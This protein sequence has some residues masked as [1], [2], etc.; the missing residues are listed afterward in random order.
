MQPE[1]CNQRSAQ[2]KISQKH[3]PAVPNA[4]V[5]FPRRERAVPVGKGFGVFSRTSS[6][7][8]VLHKYILF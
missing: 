7:L 4:S 2:A 3:F 5:V 8:V 6:R 1:D